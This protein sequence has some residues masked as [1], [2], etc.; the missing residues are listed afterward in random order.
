MNSGD[1]RNSMRTQKERS[2]GVGL[3]PMTPFMVG[4]A[5]GTGSGKT[6]CARRLAKMLASSNT[7]TLLDMDSYYNDMTFIPSNE[8][9]H[10]NYDHPDAVDFVR[11]HEDL[12]QL[13]Q[14]RTIIKPVF[15]P[16]THTRHAGGSVLMAAQV[17]IA[18]GS[19]LFV[20]ETLRNLF[21]VK[22]FVD[23][24]ADV[25]LRRRLERDVR[26]RGRALTTAIDHYMA[27]VL[28]MHD[29]FIE[30]AKQHTEFVIPGWEDTERFLDQV[31]ST[32]RKS[33]RREAD[34]YAAT[35]SA[36]RA[37]DSQTYS[38]Y[39]SAKKQENTIV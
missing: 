29:Q 32:I 34:R 19:M 25:R 4:I 16:A 7:V 10:V 26:E 15:D 18:E 11:L 1:D 30:P 24:P 5:G 3:Q 38:G 27:S 37:M 21:Q 8:R 28:P 13:R 9:E 12:L 22:I 2:V 33:I 17:V 31:V 6:T 20:D 35:L 39:D 23:T 36:D 14:W